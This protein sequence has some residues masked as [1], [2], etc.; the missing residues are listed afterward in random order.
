[1]NPNSLPQYT[2][3]PLQVVKATNT[4]KPRNWLTRMLSGNSDVDVAMFE[5]R[6]AQR[7]LRKSESQLEYLEGMISY[8]TRQISRLKRIL[9]IA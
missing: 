2:T 8:R 1:M 6:E 3:P 9:E 4:Y 7:E 5:L